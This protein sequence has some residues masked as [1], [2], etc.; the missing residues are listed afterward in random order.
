MD[1]ETFAAVVVQFNNTFKAQPNFG[2]RL[3]LIV[4]ELGEWTEAVL[5]DMPEEKRAQE[6]ADLLFVVIGAG[7][8]M[9]Y[10]MEAAMTAV[11]QK[12][13]KKIQNAENM[14]IGTDGKVIKPEDQ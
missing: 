14:K 10:D 9:G 1:F 7:H 2:L 5:K 12:N 11:A 3:G 13:W 8:S 6:M 4:E